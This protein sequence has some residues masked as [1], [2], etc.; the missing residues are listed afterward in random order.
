MNKLWYGDNLT[1]MQAMPMHSVDLIYLDPPFKSDANYN[2]LYKNMTGKPVPEQ[3]EAFFD[4]WELDAA[5]LEIARTMPVLMRQHG[6]DDQYVEFW[7]IWMQA[8][9]NTQPELL[10]YLIYMVQRL[11]YMKSILRP[12]GSIYLHCDPTASHYIKVMMDGIFGHRN[13]QNEIVWKRT[14]GHGDSRTWSRVSDY[15]LFY[16]AGQR[17][18]WNIPYEK[19]SDE[20]LKSH[21]GQ[22]DNSGRAFQLTSILSPSPRPNM[23][24]EWK[25]FPSPPMGWRFS[26]ERMTELDQKGLIWYPRHKDGTLDTSKRPRFIRYLDEQ[27]GS[28]TTTIWTDIPPINARSKDRLGYPTQKPVDLLK[29]IIE[30][31]TNPGDVVFDPFCGC[32]TTIYAAEQS[33]RKWI[34]CDI[35]ILSIKLVREVL[36]ERYRL[37]EG[38]HYEVDGIP[39][40]VEQ[41]Q[42]LFKRDP[43]QFQHWVVE[44]IGGFPMQKKVAD[45]GIDGRLYFE[46]KGE[47]GEMVLSVKGGKLRPTD[48]R[49]LRGVMEREGS[50]MG[51]FLSLQEPSKAMRGEAADAGIYEYGGVQYQRLQLLTVA[52]ILE[53]KREFH[54]PTRINTKIS[55]GQQS[56]PL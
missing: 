45:R 34:G 20:Y 30:A 44:R 37:V 48:V 28:V 51:G 43:F 2:L 38:R 52:D 54:M 7:R 22:S 49:D 18:T 29:R 31:S 46:K 33:R 23:M 50:E 55:T 42:E 14:F 24:Y 4:T 47:L 3:A 19:H 36:A 12:T 17:F 15:I 26:K 11:L 6:V 1:I 27:K 25:G 56:L 41:A 40:S 53:G 8:L 5:K 21:Y 16:T 13:F 39:V 32:G 9:R 35:A 10:A